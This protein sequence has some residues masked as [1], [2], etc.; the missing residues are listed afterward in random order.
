MPER[1]DVPGRCHICRRHAIIRYCSLCNHWFC[2]ECRDNYFA[3]GLAALKAL[4]VA[5]P[6]CCGPRDNRG[7]NPL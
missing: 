1:N 6:G 5:A 7:E 4:V 2:G 3:R